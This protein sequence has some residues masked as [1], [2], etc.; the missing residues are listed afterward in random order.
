MSTFLWI[1]FSAIYLVALVVLGVMTLR[2]GHF[3][4]FVIGIFV[5]ILWVL[6]ALIGPTSRAAPVR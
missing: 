1:L 4:L 2:K 5:P 6:G 3:V